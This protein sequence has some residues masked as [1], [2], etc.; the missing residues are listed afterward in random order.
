MVSWTVSRSGKVTMLIRPW[1]VP[2]RINHR[3][4][5]NTENGRNKTSLRTLCL[6]GL[7]L[8]VRPIPGRQLVGELLLL[9][10]LQRQD[11]FHFTLVHLLVFLLAL[12]LPV[13]GEI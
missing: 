9:A 11:E 1:L 2:V 8:D 12:Q 6:C 4:T 10:R 5:E 13:A 3:D 7:F